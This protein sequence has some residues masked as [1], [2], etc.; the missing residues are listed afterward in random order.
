M[1]VISQT[2]SD[3]REDTNKLPLMDMML[4]AEGKMFT[5]EEI[6]QEIILFSLAVS[7][8]IDFIY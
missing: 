7:M 2:M 5:D 1:F 4:E 6:F 8:R 3:F